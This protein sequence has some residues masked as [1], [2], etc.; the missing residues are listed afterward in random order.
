MG[1]E[2]W[3]GFLVPT[4]ISATSMTSMTSM[5]TVTSKVQLCWLSSIVV[6]MMRRDSPF[7]RSDGRHM[8]VLR[9]LIV[10]VILSIIIELA[11][12]AMSSMSSMLIISIATAA[13]MAIV[14]I[15][16]MTI[17]AN[18]F[19][20]VLVIISTTIRRMITSMCMWTTREWIRFRKWGTST[21]FCSRRSA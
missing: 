8:M 11:M 19:L 6:V 10:I 17:V 7:R 4:T 5:S 12:S 9:M 15:L 21:G 16:G 13:I 3:L 20:I 2:G 14:L 18:G 1:G